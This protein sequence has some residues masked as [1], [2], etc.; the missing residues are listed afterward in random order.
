MKHIIVIKKIRKTLANSES[1]KTIK[2]VIQICNKAIK[3]DEIE[4]E[5]MA[6]E[7]TKEQLLDLESNFTDDEVYGQFK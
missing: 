5:K 2:K 7:Y 4:M 1:N 6:N 3:E